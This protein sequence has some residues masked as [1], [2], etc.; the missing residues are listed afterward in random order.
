MDTHLP[1]DGPEAA[2][3]VE[4]LSVEQCRRLL[5]SAEV[6]RLAMAVAGDVDVFPVNFVVD[7]DSVV[8]RTAE[9]TKLLEVVMAGRVAFE[10]DGYDPEGGLAWSVVLKG[11]AEEIE[12][13][14]EIYR[15]QGLPLFP[16]NAAP[17]ERF[18]RVRAESVSGR[19]FRVVRPQGV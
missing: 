15:A 11:R 3:A 16:W 8:F 17:K 2:G 18:V 5:E 19:R 12:R 9:G 13:F 1:D 7:G 10:A 4:K 14:E 6:G